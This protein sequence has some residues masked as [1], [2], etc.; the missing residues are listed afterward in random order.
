MK[1]I[2]RSYRFARRTSDH[3]LM[4][5][6]EQ[7]FGLHQLERNMVSRAEKYLLLSESRLLDKPTAEGL[8]MTRIFLTILYYRVGEFERAY[9][10]VQKVKKDKVNNLLTNTVL[11]LVEGL[12]L[13]KFN[14]IRRAKHV[15][16]DIYKFKQSPAFPMLGV[17]MSS[18]CL[19]RI[20]QIEGNNKEASSYFNVGK[21]IY[22]EMGVNLHKSSVWSDFYPKF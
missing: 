11:S 22:L 21:K 15:F 6:C 8:I 4:G 2:K 9:K 1:Y 14:Q 16:L 12:L 5:L 3:A 7:K 13:L 17:A 20:A 10:L 18:V 19:V